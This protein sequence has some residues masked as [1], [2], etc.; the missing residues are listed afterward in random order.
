M[1]LENKPLPRLRLIMQELVTAGT[2]QQVRTVR[3]ALMVIMEM[4]Q[5]AA[6]QTV[7]HAHVQ[8]VQAVPQCRKP[9]R[10][11]AP[12]VPLEP[13]V[14]GTCIMSTHPATHIAWWG[15]KISK[16]SHAQYDFWSLYQS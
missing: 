6:S 4:Q 2:T 10:W 3:S 5:W 16:L 14:C 9:G 11:C 7:S 1:M 15:T 13:Q 12:T 8:G